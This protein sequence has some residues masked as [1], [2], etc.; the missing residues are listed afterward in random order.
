[1]SKICFVESFQKAVS[2]LIK[3]FSLWQKMLLI[4]FEEFQYF[5]VPLIKMIFQLKI[6]TSKLQKI[7]QNFIFLSSKDSCPILKYR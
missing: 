5:F 1:M 2:A 7:Y 6:E 3:G 4:D